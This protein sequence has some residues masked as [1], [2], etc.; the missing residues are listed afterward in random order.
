[1]RAPTLLFGEVQPNR[2][3]PP[4][5]RCGSARRVA[6]SSHTGQDGGLSIGRAGGSGDRVRIPVGI[7]LAMCLVLL[8]VG[9]ATA[10]P[11]RITFQRERDEPSSIVL[12]GEVF[13][14]GLRDVVDVWV[15]ADA[16]NAEGKVVGRGV[17]FVASFLRGRGTTTFTVKLPWAEQAH[18]FRLVVSS[19]RYASGAQSP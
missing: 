6:S 12:M 17:A 3:T 16:L 14:D 7:I 13:N 9:L 1:M 18:S 8:G 11:F 4:H 10:Q 19:F 2:T 5:P 15:T